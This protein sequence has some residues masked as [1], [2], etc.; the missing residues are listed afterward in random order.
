MTYDTMLEELS[1]RPLYLLAV[2]VALLVLMDVLLVRVAKL[3][4]TSWKKVDYV[5]LGATAIGILVAGV[6][7]QHLLSQ[8]YL[9]G[10]ARKRAATAYESLRGTL[11][12]A[13]G[14]CEQRT[15]TENSPLNFNEMLNEMRSLCAQSRA[16]AARMPA[17]MPDSCPTL[18][19]VGF[20]PFGEGSKYETS[21]V[22]SVVEG[23]ERYRAQQ[24]RCAM[25]IEAAAPSQARLVYS[26]LGPLMLVFAVALRI[27]KVTGEVKNAR[28]RAAAVRT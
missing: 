9:D 22:Q 21:F 27:T 11:E 16:A 1:A 25:F 23:A 3:D 19:D 12:R 17:K 20:M 5:W 10:T 14:L 15:R 4:D 26:V 28:D 13:T 7:A 2:F 6:E 24:K 18:D 8:R